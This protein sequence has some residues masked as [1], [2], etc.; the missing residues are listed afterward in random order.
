MKS[1]V[2]WVVKPY[3]S[4]GNISLPSSA[5]ESKGTGKA[6]PITGRGGPY[7]YERSKLPHF[8]D[9]RL[10]DGGKVVSLTRRPYFTPRKI[11]GTHFC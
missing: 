3:S 9:N 7:G 4:G 2:L 1:T 10:R 6:I 11:P 8:L 5:P